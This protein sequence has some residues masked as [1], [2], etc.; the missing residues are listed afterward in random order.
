MFYLGVGTF[1]SGMIP[2]WAAPSIP[3]LYYAVHDGGL[4]NSQFFTISPNDLSVNSIGP[5]H[6]GADIEGLD[7][8][9]NDGKIYASSGDDTNKPGYLYRVDPIDGGLIPIGPIQEEEHHFKEIDALSFNPKKDTLWG[10]AQGEGLLV[11]DKF[12]GKST[13]V[14]K[15]DGEIEDLTW[16]NEGE[17]LYA[18]ENLHGKTSYDSETDPGKN[19]VVLWAYDGSEAKEICR[20]TLDNLPEIEALEALPNNEL[21][22]GSHNSKKLLINTVDSTTCEITQIGEINTKYN[23]V[24]GISLLPAAKSPYAEYEVIKMMM[25]Q[26]AVGKEPQPLV[27]IG[28]DYSFKPAE[29]LPISEYFT[30]A[31]PANAALDYIK[32]YL[33]PKEEGNLYTEESFDFR[34]KKSNGRYVVKLSQKYKGIPVFAAGLIVHIDESGKLLYITGSVIPLRTL[35]LS[36]PAGNVNVNPFL[37]HSD[38]YQL[39]KPQASPRSTDLFDLDLTVLID[40]EKAAQIAKA[41]MGQQYGVALSKIKTGNPELMIYNPGLVGEGDYENRLTWKINTERGFGEDVFVDV[42]TAEVVFTVSTIYAALDRKI[43]D[44]NN[45]SNP[46]PGTLERDEGDPA[47]PI[48]DVNSAYDFLADTYDFYFNRHGRDSLDGAGT[49]LVATVRHCNPAVPPCPM[50]NAFWNDTLMQMEFGDGW[51]VDDMVGHELT[52]AVTDNESDLVYKN[53]SGAINESFS[54]VW[55]EFIDLGNGSGNDTPA[56]RWEIGEDLTIGSLRDMEDPTTFGH[57]DR[58]T[59]SLYHCNATDFGGVHT[60]SGVNNRAASLLVD[61]GT[62]NGQTVTALGIDKTAHIYYQAQVKHL[63]SDSNY[64]KL[65]NALINSCNDLIGTNGITAADCAQ[66]E[67][68]IEAVEMNRIPCIS[69]T[70]TTS[71]NNVDVSFNKGNNPNVDADYWAAALYNGTLYY[72]DSSWTWTV[73]AAPAYQGKLVD[74]TAANIY[75][76]TPPLPS[77]STVDFYVGVDMKMNGTTDAPYRYIK[78]TFVSP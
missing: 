3:D 67:A 32:T 69:L 22:L 36:T 7:V 17:I 15:Y 62:F 52:H 1:F 4:N 20:K 73:T 46:L 55:G 5:V 6:K 78:H 24:E 37:T 51:A 38:S 50:M 68:T 70:I 59:S 41:Y 13:L 8:D 35:K 57:P 23:D 64:F 34:Y 28:Q 27:K 9:P 65:S 53:Q 25:Q 43:Y 19:G 61:G 60:N 39:A 31:N 58:I 54:D 56:V 29:D 14:L 30:P 26:T 75:K 16:D 63:N 77:G 71:G 66:V 21:L 44:N 45:T 11:I 74:F 33:F 12:T 72:L 40:A 76:G 18:V 48:A 10:W 2:V 47:S 42:Q 49:A